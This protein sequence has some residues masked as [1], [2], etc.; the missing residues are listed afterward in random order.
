MK[1]TQGY[2]TDR[3]AVSFVDFAGK[4]MKDDL[5]KKIFQVLI[6]MQS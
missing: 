5:V 4:S 1:K 3:A 6:T 2:R